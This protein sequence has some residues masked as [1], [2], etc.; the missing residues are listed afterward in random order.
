MS[1]EILK[2]Q[3]I[4]WDG[5]NLTTRLNSVVL[6][7]SADALDD[8]T[9][10][11]TNRSNAPGLRTASIQ[12]EGI[13]DD[14]A[15][16]TALASTIAGSDKLIT[17]CRNST[18]GALAWFLNAVHASY[19]PIK[20]NVGQLAGF[21]AGGV[22]RSYPLCRGTLLYNQSD[23]DQSADGDGQQLGAILSTETLYAGLHVLAIDDNAGDTIDVIIESDDNSG[24][25]SATTRITFDQ[26]SDIGSQFK[27]LTGPVTDDY[28]RASHTIAGDTPAFAAVVVWAKRT[29]PPA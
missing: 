5:Y 13:Y 6:E 18:E 26:M 20:G 3:L 1:A 23:L 29:T 8:T 17:V 12:I 21:S 22:S 7:V 9:F 24:F 4:L 15:Y 25:T 14:S 11:C 2:Q 10:G 28:W 16:D 27:T 19:D